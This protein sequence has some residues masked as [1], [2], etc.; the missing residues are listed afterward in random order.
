[1]LQK[2][3]SWGPQQNNNIQKN[4]HK[5]AV[6]LEWDLPTPDEGDTEADL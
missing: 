3:K 1:M 5:T 6:I 4:N 2:T